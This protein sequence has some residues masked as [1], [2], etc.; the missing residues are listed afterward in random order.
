MT[1]VRAVLQWLISLGNKPLML[2]V[3]IFTSSLL[4]AQGPS[5]SYTP[6]PNSCLQNTPQTLTATITD[7]AGVPLSG[8]GV[9]T[10]YWRRNFGPY[11]AVSGTSIGG[12][13][14]T[15]T[16][17]GDISGTVISYYIAAQN[18]LDEVSVMPSAGAA[19]L[20]ANPPAAATPP[21]FP[22]QF[23]IQNTMSGV[24]TIGIGGLYSFLTITDAVNAYNNSCLAGNI[25]FLL[26]I[27]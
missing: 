24:Y 23:I 17:G 6:L 15:F 27:I 13:Q 22:S 9:P 12:D 20:T 5:I 2:L 1:Q 25:T 3:G 26:S 19:G 14:Y 16:F 4:F 11:N 8:A 7:A 21:D 10:L 18:N